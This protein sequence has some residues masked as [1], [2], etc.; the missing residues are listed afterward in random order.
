MFPPF[1]LASRQRQFRR[2][3][4]ITLSQGSGAQPRRAAPNRSQ[5]R[6]LHSRFGELGRKVSRSKAMEVGRIVEILCDYRR[7]Q[8]VPEQIEIVP[9]LQIIDLYA[10]RVA[11]EFEYLVHA[12]AGTV[13]EASFAEWPPV[14]HSAEDL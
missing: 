10:A 3:S 5:A 4:G 7:Q 12:E 14:R 6:L 11:G 13:E 8:L 9:D 1:V 2:D